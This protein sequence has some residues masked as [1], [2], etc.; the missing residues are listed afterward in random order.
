MVNGIALLTF[1]VTLALF[2]RRPEYYTAPL[3]LVAVILVG[4]ISLMTIVAAWLVRRGRY[5]A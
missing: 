1:P 3:F 2:M 5:H 4:V